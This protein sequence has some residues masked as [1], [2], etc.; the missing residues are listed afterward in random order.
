MRMS[1]A[2][3]RSIIMSEKNTA[4]LKHIGPGLISL[5]RALGAE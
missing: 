1:G 2:T 5:P 3:S 4:L